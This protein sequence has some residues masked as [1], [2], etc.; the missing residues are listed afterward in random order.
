MLRAKRRLRLAKR[1]ANKR[2]SYSFLGAYALCVFLMVGNPAPLRGQQLEGAGFT[3]VTPEEVSVLVEPG[4]LDTAPGLQ[5]LIPE[6]DASGI[7]GFLIRQGYQLFVW[8][9]TPICLFISTVLDWI[10]ITRDP[11]TIDFITGDVGFFL[12]V[13][14]AW[15]PLHEFLSHVFSTVLLLIALIPVRIASAFIFRAF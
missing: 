2:A 1:T 7:Y 14:D 6:S 12:G 8:T 9:V 5:T 10:G 11:V 4:T 13:V 15:I 3:G